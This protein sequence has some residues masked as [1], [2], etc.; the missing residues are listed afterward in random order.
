LLLSVLVAAYTFGLSFTT[1][2]TVSVSILSLPD[3]PTSIVNAS[4]MIVLD[5]LLLALFG[6]FQAAREAFA[7][8]EARLKDDAV[9]DLAWHRVDEDP[10]VAD[11]LAYA[12]YVD[13]KPQR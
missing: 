5:V 10:N 8:L 4:G 1:R 7:E 9:T 3:I 11:F 12:M 6:T 13:G 2:A